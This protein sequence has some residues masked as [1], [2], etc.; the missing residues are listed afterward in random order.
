MGKRLKYHDRFSVKPPLFQSAYLM[1]YN[2]K[3]VEEYVK[4]IR[5]G[6]NRNFAYNIEERIERFFSHNN[7]T[8]EKLK[9]FEKEFNRTFEKFHNHKNSCNIVDL[10]MMRF[11]LTL[12]CIYI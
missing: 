5:R 8:E 11:L 3:T 6:N 9:I 7:F 2:T 1:H 12:F 10:R 4:K